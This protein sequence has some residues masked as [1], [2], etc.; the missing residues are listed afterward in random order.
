MRITSGGNVGMGTTSPN[1]KLEIVSGDSEQLVLTSTSTSNLAGIFLNPANTT[2]SSFIGGTGND[3][4]MNTVG[5]EKMRITS[6]GNVGIG[7]TTPNNILEIRKD[8]AADTAF[9]INNRNST[10]SGSTNSLIFGG[11]RDSDPSHQVAKISVIKTPSSAAGDLEQRGDLAFYTQPAT[12][13]TTPLSVVVLIKTPPVAF[14]DIFEPNIVKGIKSA[15]ES[16]NDAIAIPVVPPNKA[17]DVMNT[18]LS[19]PLFT[20]S[21]PYGVVVPIPMLPLFNTVNA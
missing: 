21:L 16:N 5:A 14:S 15:V 10:S 19:T 3:I 9:W 17:S 6:G 18:F 8:Q 13:N 20:T 12:A 1:R 4:V 2:F 7:T 11:Y